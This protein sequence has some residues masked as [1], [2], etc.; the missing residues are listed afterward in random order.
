ME[1]EKNQNAH[2]R[3]LAHAR[4]IAVSVL[5]TEGAIATFMK[6]EVLVQIARGEQIEF[7]TLPHLIQTQLQEEGQSIN[8]NQVREL[9]TKQAETALA[10][11]QDLNAIFD[12]YDQ[13]TILSVIKSD[14]ECHEAFNILKK[15][16]TDLGM[17]ADTFK[18]L[19]E[20]IA[21][22]KLKLQD[23]NMRVSFQAQ[24]TQNVT[25]TL[26]Q[27]PSTIGNGIQNLGRDVNRFF[28]EQN[29][30]GRWPHPHLS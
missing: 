2:I 20:S 16:N 29:L 1:A 26:S 7:N 6:N 17:D 9:Y 3:T 19:S 25:H 13:S 24:L 8:P 10:M 23:P 22:L 15:A 21:K 4:D 27:M 11:I 30:R 12:K 5:D 28:T 14:A 18:G